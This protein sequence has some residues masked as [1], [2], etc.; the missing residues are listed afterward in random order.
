MGKTLLIQVSGAMYELDKENT[1]DPSAAPMPKRQARDAAGSRTN[2]SMVLSPKTNNSKTLLQSPT[3]LPLGSPAKA[4]GCSESPLKPSVSPL[5]FAA[6]AATVGLANMV[7][8]KSVVATIARARTNSKTIKTSAKANSVTQPR[9]VSAASN[10]SGSSGTSTGTIVRRVGAAI[11]SSV[12]PKKVA[13]A[14]PA[15]PKKAVAS[16]AKA[17]ATK[18]E[19]AVV[20]KRTLRK[21]PQGV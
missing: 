9:T 15:V 3:R 18:P 5:K 19:V 1:P 21:R 7:G 10:S 17:N 11:K 13:S 14:K 6:A 2:P 12:A 8:G 16:R 20:E 4:V